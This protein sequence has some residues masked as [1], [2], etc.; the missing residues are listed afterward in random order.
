MFML[1]IANPV[2]RRGRG[3][4]YAEIVTAELD[5]RGVEHRLCLTDNPLHAT[6]IAKQAAEAGEKLVLC[7][8][9]DG[10]LSEV[11]GGLC[12]SDTALGIVPAGTG[13]DFARYLGLPQDPLKAL[14]VALNGRERVID[15]G[16]ANGRAFVNIA[17]SGID[18]SVLRHTLFYKRFLHGLPAY[19]M[20]VLR[21]LATFSPSEAEITA[22]GETLRLRCML[23]NVANGRFFG[24]GMMV[25]PEADASDGLFDVHYVDEISRLRV[26]TLLAGFIKGTYVRH[27]FVHSFRC[28]ELTV[29]FGDA[30]LQLD[31]EISS[32][33]LVAYKL[34]KSA[35]RVRVGK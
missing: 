2:S 13:D 27:S 15:L 14:D 26:L 19:V 20:G 31:G 33:G 8:G 30:S 22:N 32:S 34:L 35:L 1:R 7:V 16:L 4:K 29:R 11:A 3:A 21:A 10:T 6:K 5:A 9:G 23:V 28:E 17:G 18:V 25:A 12:G 24:G